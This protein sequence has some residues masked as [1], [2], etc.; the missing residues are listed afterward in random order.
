VKAVVI[1]A[2]GHIGNAIVR[3]LLDQGIEVTATSRKT[4]PGYNLAGLPVR[5]ACGDSAAFGQFD[6]WV[7]GHDIVVDA[8]A[9]YPI[10]VV[11]SAG[12]PDSDPVSD[13]VQRTRELL[14]AVFKYKALLVSIGSFATIRSQRRGFD[15]AQYEM[16]RRAHPYFAVKEA[17]ETEMV[18]AARN[19]IKAVLLNPTMCVGPWDMRQREFC[20]VPRLLAGE[21]PAMTNQMIN[22]IDVRDVA[23]A[24]I[25]ALKAK[26]FGDPIPLSG[27]NISVDM[28]FSW[29]CE[30]GQV[31]PPRT[32]I[33]ASLAVAGSYWAEL[34]LALLGQSTPVPSVFLMLASALDC[35]APD[36]RQIELGIAPRP[37]SGAILDAVDW[38]RRIGYC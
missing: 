33:P 15:A 21:V 22:L 23:D 24:T 1:G 9:P 16:M 20:I 29:I 32:Y 4:V 38:Y 26:K 10:N 13:A 17:I 18:N 14:D 36:R 31:R 6:A 30:I 2:T 11:R 35:P 3:A 28:L 25:A 7:S 37:L 8:A 12:E 27:H 34:A 5:F 19:G